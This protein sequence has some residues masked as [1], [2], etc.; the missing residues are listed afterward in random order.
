MRKEARSQKPEARRLLCAFFILASGFWLL[1]SAHAETL[2]KIVAVVDGRIITLSDIRQES[3]VRSILGEKRIDDDAV[4][5]QLIEGYLIESQLVGFPGINVSD[6]EIAD[7]V[8][9]LQERE[10]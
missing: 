2:D 9:K 5:Q 10:S 6:Q 8:E 7:A 1:T 3:A 4:M